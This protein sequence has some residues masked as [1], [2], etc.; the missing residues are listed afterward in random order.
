MAAK[1]SQ[2]RESSEESLRC[3][4]GRLFTAFRTSSPCRDETPST[5]LS[6]YRQARWPAVILYGLAGSGITALAWAL[7]DD[8]RVGRAFRDG[9]LW[10]DSSRNPKKETRRLCGALGLGRAPGERWGEGWRRTRPP[11]AG[12]CRQSRI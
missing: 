2:R 9:I 4:Q 8:E 7:A 12:G 1:L 5:A 10:A 11:Q 3:T 6:S